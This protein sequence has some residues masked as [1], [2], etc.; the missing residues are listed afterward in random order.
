[1]KQVVSASSGT[2]NN[3]GILLNST[4]VPVILLQATPKHP[5]FLGGLGYVHCTYSTDVMTLIVHLCL[6]LTLL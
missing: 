5:F 2:W 6:G 3:S 1:M 4:P